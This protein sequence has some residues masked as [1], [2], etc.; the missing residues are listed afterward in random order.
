MQ[1]YLAFITSRVRL[2]ADGE[3]ALLPGG[4]IRPVSAANDLGRAVLY[5]VQVGIACFFLVFEIFVMIVALFSCYSAVVVYTLL[6]S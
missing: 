1:M 2:L 6:R 5:V 3:I 4:W